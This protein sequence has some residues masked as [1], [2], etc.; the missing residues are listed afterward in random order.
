[1]NKKI[2]KRA[3]LFLIGSSL[4]SFGAIALSKNFDNA[5]KH[6]SALLQ[7]KERTYKNNNRKTILL[8]ADTNLNAG[9]TTCYS[10]MTGGANINV[11]LNYNISASKT[12]S[13]TYHHEDYANALTTIASDLFEISRDTITKI[14]YNKIEKTLIFEAPLVF[15][16]NCSYSGGSGSIYPSH[17]HGPSTNF[18]G[19]FEGKM[20]GHHK[21]KGKVTAK[22]NADID[23]LI[24]DSKKIS[25]DYNY[26]LSIDNDLTMRGINSNN[27]SLKINNEFF[28]AKQ[29]MMSNQKWISQLQSSEK[30]R[31]VNSTSQFQFI[32]D[33][34]NDGTIFKFSDETIVKTVHKSLMLNK[35]NNLDIWLERLDNNQITEEMMT[36]KIDSSIKSIIGHF[37][38]T[39][40]LESNGILS[41]EEYKFLIKWKTTRNNNVQTIEEEIKFNK[42]SKIFYFSDNKT[43]L[44]IGIDDYNGDEEIIIDNIILKFK[45]SSNREIKLNMSDDNQLINLVDDKYQTNNIFDIRNTI[46]FNNFKLNE[47]WRQWLLKQGCFSQEEIIDILD[48]PTNW[49]NDEKFNDVIRNFS[50]DSPI[51]IA[52]NNLLKKENILKILGTNKIIDRYTN[53]IEFIGYDSMNSIKLN[54]EY[55]N[56]NKFGVKIDDHIITHSITINLQ[57]EKNNEDIENII[58]DQIVYTD[59]KFETISEFENYVLDNLI[60]YKDHKQESEFLL[61]TNLTKHDWLENSFNKIE[62]TYDEDQPIVK[63]S[64]W[65]NTIHNANQLMKQQLNLQ[66]IIIYHDDNAIITSSSNFWLIFSLSASAIVLLLLISLIIWIRKT[67]NQKN[68]NPKKISKKNIKQF[69]KVL[70]DLFI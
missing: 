31:P 61:S 43:N 6:D 21:T 32:I 2:W 41:C 55:L 30:Y 64:Y 63:L 22:L 68:S 25:N 14:N 51:F 9:S 37:N 50:P 10:T 8:K 34:L 60:N 26:F 39:N 40:N 28:Y 49:I 24:F 12:I 15:K 20:Y 56:I 62:V 29:I 33:K 19:N 67:K 57:P 70:D 13:D 1:M 42:E 66:P 3:S 48:N 69:S 45:D 18:C 17:T 4:L 27:F 46:K 16:W 58:S 65:M 36:S 44:H 5:K 54:I 23:E 38:I 52:D 7:S 59:D 35:E 53:K 11:N 47:E